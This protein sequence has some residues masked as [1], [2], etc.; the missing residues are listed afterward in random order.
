MATRK[1]KRSVSDRMVFGVAGGLAEYFD[2]DPVIVRVGFVLLTFANLLGLIGYV[3]LTI[4]T[5]K[6][7]TEPSTVAD[8]ARQNLSD[9]PREAADAGRRAGEQFRTTGGGNGTRV[10]LILGAVLIVIGAWFLLDNLG[11]KSI[12]LVIIWPLLIVLAGGLLL[13]VA[14]R[15]GSR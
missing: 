3:I 1:L 12:L 6:A 14:L 15:Q 8:A 11:I 9:L 2:I 5:P 13:L 7:E 4:V 10:L